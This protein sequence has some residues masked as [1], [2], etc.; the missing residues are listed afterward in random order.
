MQNRNIF[1]VSMLTMSLLM[2]CNLTKRV[3]GNSKENV[4]VPVAEVTENQQ[5]TGKDVEQSAKPVYVNTVS[6]KKQVV[7]ASSYNR[8]LIYAKTKEQIKAEKRLAKAQAKAKKT[9]KP[10]ILIKSELVPKTTEPTVQSVKI[11]DTLTFSNS[12]KIALANDTIIDKA[13]KPVKDTVFF[14]PEDAEKYIRT[15]AQ[16]KKYSTVA[17]SFSTLEKAY[18]LVVDL[19]QK[20]TNPLSLRTKKECSGLFQEPITTGTTLIL[21][22]WSWSWT[23]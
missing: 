13:L 16:L 8:Q 10:V 11:V 9:S 4:K 7:A 12:G 2:S 21:T 17:G 14:K 6:G 18:E 19:V 23:T 5:L 15:N 3:S 22:E 20:N 1:F